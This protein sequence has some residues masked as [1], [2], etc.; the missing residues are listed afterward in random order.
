M[1]C[2]MSGIQF[3]I[4]LKG[5]DNRIQAFGGCAVNAI[6]EVKGQQPEMVPMA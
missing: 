1:D 6:S 4:I 5:N 3:N 2:C